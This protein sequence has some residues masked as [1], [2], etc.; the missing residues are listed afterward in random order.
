MDHI[1][2]G[3][4]EF[5]MPRADDVKENFEGV[6]FDIESIRLPIES[7]LI[8][9]PSVRDMVR[10]VTLKPHELLEDELF[11]GLFMGSKKKWW[12]REE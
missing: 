6:L 11:R 3:T 5:L 12:Y 7:N 1:M 9:I 4:G 10:F 2:R 8:G